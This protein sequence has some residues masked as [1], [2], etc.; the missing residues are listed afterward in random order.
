MDQRINRK[1]FTKA[2]K[3]LVGGVNSP[4]R[5]FNAVGGNPVLL[6]R[7]RGSK[8]IDYDGNIYI[9]YVLSW[10]SL[11]L[12]HAYPPVL[13][14]LKKTSGRGFSF[15][16]TNRQEIEL[17]AL[18]HDAVP[19]IEKVR[20][21]NSGTEAVMGAVRLARGYTG[22][23]KILKFTHSYHGHAD[24]L[25]VKGGSGLATLKIASSAGVPEDFVRNTLIAPFSDRESVRRIFETHG[26]KIAAVIFEPVGGNFGVIPADIGFMKFLREITQRYGALLIAD[27]VITGFR[28]N[29]G[30]FTHFLG[31]HPDL[32]CLGK[33]IGGGLPVGAYGGAGKIMDRLAPLGKVYQASTFAGNPLVMQAGLS[34]LT[35]LRRL[36]NKYSHLEDNALYLAQ[37]FKKI[38]SSL[39]LGLDV[40][41]FGSMFSIKFKD[42]KIFSPVYR[43]LLRRGIYLAPSE[44]EA[45]FISFAHTKKDLEQTLGQ[46]DLALGEARARKRGKWK[47]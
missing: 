28:F 26:R 17:A 39:D 7:G 34:T 14:D 18:L 15:G 11:I 10:G 45:N 43:D 29:F 20:F 47:I 4:V 37:G 33:I 13:R 36:E 38:A 6:G 22:R 1:L 24:Y 16:A 3:Y 46:F 41:Q 5:A 31:I 40:R 30:S 23:D 32:I 35:A 2:K 8:V 12:G 25:L 44:L 42:K 21:V 27:E 9:D 19:I